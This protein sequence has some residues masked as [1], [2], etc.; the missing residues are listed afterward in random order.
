MRYST[1]SDYPWLGSIR[2]PQRYILKGMNLN[3][4][5]RFQDQRKF[6]RISRSIEIEVSQL[7]FPLANAVIKNGTSVNIGENGIRITTS[8]PYPPKTLL[9][10]KINIIG[11]EG[12]KKPFSRC[13]D[14]SS[15]TGLTVVGEVVW[16]NKNAKDNDYHLGVR[17]LNIY[18]DDAKALIRY[19]KA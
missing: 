9:N 15:G 7:A 19:L 14:I 18:E 13:I 1:L 6:P 12:F 10:L 3:K 4:S 5:Q 8:D 2:H 17:F 11:W 16:C